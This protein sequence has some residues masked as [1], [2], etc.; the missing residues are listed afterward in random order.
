[1][2]ETLHSG[3][4]RY[5]VTGTSAGT[6]AALRVLVDKGLPT[7]LLRP[8]LPDYRAEL[9]RFYEA[10][11][12]SPAWV[13]DHKPTPQALALIHVLRNAAKEGLDP[14]DYDAPLWNSRLAL[15]DRASS[16]TEQSEE[17]RFDVALTVSAMRYV[18][19]LRWGRAIPDSLRYGANPADFSLGGFLRRQIVEST[20]VQASLQQLEPSFPAYRRTAEAL[21]TYSKL[22]RE[23]DGELLPTPVK[24][25][26]PEDSYDGMPRLIQ[27]LQRLGDLSTEQ[28]TPE[29]ATVYDGDLVDAVKHF[30]E[31]HGLDP[32]GI[33]GRRTLHALNTPL[34]Q[35]ILQLQLALERWRWLPHTFPRPPILVNI[36]EFAVHA[37]DQDFRPAL[38]KKAIVGRSL[39]HRTPVFASEMKQVI[40]R[41]PWNVPPSI[42]IRELVP[43]IRKD[44]EYLRKGDY[45]VIDRQGT[46]VSDG[47]VNDEILKALRSGKLA[48]RQSPGS[49]NSL[50][51]VKFLFPNDYDVYMHGTPA[52]S[53]FSHSRRDFSHGCIRV[54]APA[55]LAAWVLRDQPQWTPDR[56]RAAMNGNRTVWVN[57]DHPVP[58]L[59]V[60]TTAMV[61]EDGTV[62]FFE[63]LYKED[64]A[65][66]KAISARYSTLE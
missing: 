37:Y 58:V 36:P 11:D 21:A 27:L 17:A 56:I 18:S 40:F 52:M 41:P 46:V 61:D 31:R 59:I 66:A 23:D 29:T 24:A 33:I 28:A 22:A 16:L 42:Q 34:Q 62:R 48:L 45:E 20:D 25:V 8:D 57:L 9:Q 44:P 60:Y 1:M 64:T 51:L 19:D 2:A 30:Q 6:S 65:L 32:D 43:D 50:G 26:R 38:S 10:E 35:R 15:L 5:A 7:G 14:A 4:S 12:Y 49:K 53:L 54:E 63:D 55:E 3:V 13:R 47:E 39:R